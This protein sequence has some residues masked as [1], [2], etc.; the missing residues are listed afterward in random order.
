MVISIFKEKSLP[1]QFWDKFDFT[2]GS[3]HYKETFCDEDML[4]VNY[5]RDIILDAGFYCG[6]FVVY[7]IFNYIWEVPVAVYHCKKEENFEK[8]INLAIEQVKKELEIKR[9]SNYGKIWD[10]IK[11]GLE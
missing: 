1:E 8:I 7:I 3:I 9:L 10:T 2:P 6:T 5:P 4:L 11:I